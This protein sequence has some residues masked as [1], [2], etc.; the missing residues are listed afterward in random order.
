MN[1]R[2]IFALSMIMA[3]VSASVSFE[4]VR[5][6][7]VKGNVQLYLQKE[8]KNM[9]A[10]QSGL[11]IERMGSNLKIEST[12]NSS[13]RIKVA[14]FSKD[15]FRA[16]QHLKVHDSSSVLSNNIKPDRLEVY[17]DSQGSVQLTQVPNIVRISNEG[18]G[19][20]EAYWVTAPHLELVA[21]NGKIKVGGQVQRLFMTGSGQSKVD[22]SGVVSQ[23]V[24]VRA[25]DE[26]FMKVRA[27]NYISMNG[28]DEALV[29]SYRDAKFIN[30]VTHDGAALIHVKS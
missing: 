12:Q 26:S 21:L 22:A 30:E 3:S 10:T 5:Q 8:D 1:L 6:I 24:W 20:V 11:K 13:N 9:S 15:A 19:N 29:E 14:I 4:G 25:E 18:K 7:E 27:T 23:S 16:L 17:S 28:S 2:W